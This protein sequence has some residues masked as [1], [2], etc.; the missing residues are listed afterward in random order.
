MEKIQDNQETPEEVVIPE[1]FKNSDGSVNKEALLKSYTDLEKDRSRVVSER[2]TLRK[3]LEAQKLNETLAAGIEKIV[4]NTTPKQEVAPSYEEHM[5]KLAI[6][7]AEEMGLEPDD[8]GVKLAV[9]LNSETAKSASSWIR[10]EVQALKD[11]HK[12]ELD[13]MRGF[14]NN[15]KSDRIKSTPE[16][17]AHKA[18]IDELVQE[19]GADEGKIIQFVLKKAA[20]TSDTSA[21]PPSMPNSRITA[22]VAVSEYWNS[23]EERQQSVQYRGEEATAKMEA[24]GLARIKRTAEEM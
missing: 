4:A 6:G 22:E 17:I 18:E 5:S 21:P 16:Y 23:Q 12:R 13:E 7:Y 15:D 2:D 9:K 20:N 11:E 10:D 1:K 24:A 8:P 14:I 19:T 3:D